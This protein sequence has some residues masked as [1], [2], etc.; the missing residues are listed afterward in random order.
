MAIAFTRI[1]FERVVFL[2]QRFAI[3]PNGI[4]FKATSFPH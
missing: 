3:K 4:D 1:L 2:Y